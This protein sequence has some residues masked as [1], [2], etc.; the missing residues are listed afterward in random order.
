[1][2]AAASLTNAVLAVEPGEQVSVEIMVRNT[3]TVVDQFTCEVI[4]DAAGWTTVE[5]A[6][7]SLFPGAEQAV[8][9]GFH[10][11]RAP[12][13]PAGPMPFGIKISPKEDPLGSTVE[14]GVLEIAAFADTTAE[15]L[16]RTSRGRRR[17]AHE[18]AVD[19]RGNTRLLGTLT[20]VDPDELLTFGI[21]PSSVMVDPGTAQFA[22]VRVVPRKRFWRGPPQT[23]PFQVFVEPE[24]GTPLAV[25]GAMLQEAVL[26]KW[27][28]RAI[29]LGL[30]LLALLLALWFALLRP[31][32]ESAARRAAEE[33]VAEQVA[34]QL[35]PVAEQAAQAQEQAA[36][37]Q[38]QAAQAE[39]QAGAAEETAGAA[40]ETA[41]TTQTT[42]EDVI[43]PGGTFV[44]G[45]EPFDFRLT[46][47]VVAGG[48]GEQTFTVPQN[49]QFALT[50]IVLQN[51][52]GDSGVLEIRRRAGGSTSTLL[53]VRL[54]NFRDLDYHFVSPVTF[55]AGQSVVLFVSCQNPTT[56]T[57]GGP[58]P[59][60]PCNAASY[61]SGFQKAVEQ[62]TN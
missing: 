34:E 54:E 2:G 38:E 25:D 41:A 5:P 24:V 11:P 40:Q 55:Q 6:S 7:V 39:T 61:F 44:A 43:A 58:P 20:A 35:A 60:V 27:L 1:M 29:L 30:I 52:Q 47:S 19:N 17:A 42:L 16:P 8:Q 13:I 31:T 12:N 26:P 48:S 23:R 15:L 3:G 21:S 36:Q 50:D 62:A 28:P 10:P 4:G 49:Q 51:P 32:L 46:R 59:N 37:A 53:Q 45:G 57:E 22:R 18:L 14:E 9:V 56:A 33:Q